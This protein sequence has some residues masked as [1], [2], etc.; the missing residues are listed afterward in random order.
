MADRLELDAAIV[1]PITRQVISE[2]PG[3]FTHVLDVGCGPGAVAMILAELVPDAS[4]TALDS[5]APLLRRVRAH[6]DRAGIAHRVQTVEGDLEHDL[7]SLPPADL[8]WAG[9]VLHHVGQPVATLQ[10]LHRQLTPGGTLAMMEFGR[11]PTVLPDH[12]PLVTSGVW[13]RFQAATTASLDERLGLDPVAIDWPAFLAVAGFVD[14]IDRGLEAVHPVP[15]TDTVR[16][17]LVP[18]VERGV[19]MA[20][21]RLDGADAAALLAFAA[22]VP[23][24]DDLTVV[25]RRR[26]VTARRPHD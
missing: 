9:M 17:W 13:A 22:E 5:S 14:V 12:D 10:R 7:P 11:T 6:A 21:D 1:E 19:E 26:I 8:V 16:A 20:G 25:A 3:P 4:V 24:R 2:L 15:P 18:H 23:M